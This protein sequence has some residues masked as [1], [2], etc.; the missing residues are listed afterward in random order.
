M[1]ILITGGTGFIGSHFIQKYGCQYQFTVL[2]RNKTLYNRPYENNIQYID[3]LD[4][5]HDLNAFDAVINLAGEPIADKRWSEHQKELICQSRWQITK[6]LVDLILSSSRPPK[7]F[8]SGSAIGWYGRQTEQAIDESFKHFNNEFSHHICQHWEEIALKAKA[9]TRVCLLRTGIVLAKKHGALKKM[10]PSFCL[11]FG[12]HIGSGEQYMSWIHINDMIA[13]IDFLLHQNEIHGAVN[14]T[15]PAPVTNSVFCQQ[16][17]TTMNRRSWFHLP[18][19]L[20]HLIFGEMGDLL[21]YGQN[22][23]PAKLLE[24]GYQFNYPSI[25]QAFKQIFSSKKP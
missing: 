3:S 17:A 11:G 14:M 20:I 24:H 22:V 5:Y 4:S 7:V 6:Q 1:N 8:L 21:I 10:L 12:G 15:A 23:T 25:E 19:A 13:A 2:T 9:K 18:A 16:L